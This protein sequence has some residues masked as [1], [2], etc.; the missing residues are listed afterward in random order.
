MAKTEDKGPII[1]D[2]TLREFGQNVPAAYLHLFTPS[3]RVKIAHGLMAAGFKNME[4][5]SCVH[6]Q[7][8]PA[9]EEGAL[10]QIASMLGR[11]SGLNLIT[12]VPNKAGYRRF[13][14][15][16]LGPEGYDHT[17]GIFFSAVEAHNLANLRCTIEE[18]VETNRSIVK[19]ASSRGIRV[20]AYIS[21]VFGYFDME[22]ET[23]IEADLERVSRYTDQFFDLGAH[24]VTYS[25]LQGVAGPSETRRILETLLE[26][27]KGRDVDRLGYHPHHVSGEAA[28]S[29]SK[30]AYDLGI[31]RF[32]ASL[33]GA[34]G[35]VTGAPGN[36]PT[37]DLI[38]FFETHKIYT[39]LDMGQ[40]SSLA[41]F[42]KRE[43]Y[44]R[45]PLSSAI[46]T[47]PLR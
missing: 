46:D 40:I 2:V 17:L 34:G 43:L 39:G 26:K 1:T 44:D 35:C 42:I 45:I 36:Q 18:A 31:R 22:T 19:D 4:I 9:M 32:D 37:E 14:A 7:I 20:V 28:I 12:L 41:A 5:L 29:N 30:I 15:L 25:D 3:I 24:T 6:P 23:L 10:R 21:A 47:P 8:A 16:N 38:R 13:L 27:R 33:G 11:V